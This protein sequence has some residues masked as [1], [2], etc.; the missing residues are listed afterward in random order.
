MIQTEEVP[1]LVTKN[2]AYPGANILRMHPLNGLLIQ[3]NCAARPTPTQRE[4]ASLIIIVI[5]FISNAHIA[6]M[7]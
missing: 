7:G 5:G 3:D 2:F 4:G 6:F 1:N